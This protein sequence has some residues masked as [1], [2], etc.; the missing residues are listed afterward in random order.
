MERSCFFFGFGENPHN[1]CFPS[2]NWVNGLHS[3]FS[4]PLVNLR[5]ELRRPDYG[6]YSANLSR[7]TLFQCKMSLKGGLDSNTR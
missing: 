1:L 7:I 3:R 4:G 2:V 5:A 6:K